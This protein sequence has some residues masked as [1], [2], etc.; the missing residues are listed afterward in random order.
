MTESSINKNLTAMRKEIQAYIGSLER[1][2]QD[3]RAAIS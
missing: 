3:E 1:G 2:A